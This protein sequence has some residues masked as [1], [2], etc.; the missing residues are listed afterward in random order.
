MDVKT[1]NTSTR[2]ERKM[3]R[4]RQKIIQVA[5]G[6]FKEQGFAAT[7]MEQIAEEADI[8]KGTLYNYF[9]AKEAILSSY[10][11]RSF[12]QNNAERIAKLR[13]IRG[14][15][16]RIR[17]IFGQLISGVQRQSDIFEKYIEYRI[18]NIISFH[19]D[20]SGDS[21]LNAL[22]REIIALGQGEKDIREDWPLFMLEDLF[23]FAFIE[24]AKQ[25]FRDRKG[26]DA[27]QAIQRGVEVFMAGAGRP[28]K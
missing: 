24:V 20:K 10:I 23:E 22:G 8:A 25:F 14:T 17:L 28:N 16:E 6:L 7:T 12:Q 5:V 13:E 27:N 2:L 11:N 15:P 4:T 21:G 26:F 9:P 3:E 18:Q 1:A 19:T